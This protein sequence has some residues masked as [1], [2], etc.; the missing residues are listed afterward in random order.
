MHL[1]GIVN[2]TPDSFSDGGKWD[3]AHE[4]I[5]HGRA[6]I[7]DGASIIDIGGES[8]R[9]GAQPLTWE[10]EWDRIAEVVSELAEIGRERAV[11]ISVDTYHSETARRAVNAGASIINDVTGGR[12][13]PDMFDTIAQLSC[14]YI[15]QHSRGT[16]ATMN[17]LANYHDATS[18]VIDELLQARDRAVDSGISPERIIL[19]PGIGF[20]KMGDTDWEIL[21]NID[22]INALGHRVLVGVSRKRFIGRLVGDNYSDRDI[23]TAAISGYLAQHAVWGVRVHDVHT[24]RLVLATLSAI[25]HHQTLAN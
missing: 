13:A 9:P 22:H 12:A 1:M 7:E 23:S 6:L 15:L 14:D 2:V 16:S 10:E 3:S 17:D 19:D 11:A 4:A 25:Q 20:A 18:D 8:T 21:A 24:S 5:A